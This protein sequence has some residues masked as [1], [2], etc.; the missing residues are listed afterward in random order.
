MKFRIIWFTC[1]FLFVFIPDAVFGDITVSPL[2]ITNIEYTDNIFR[3]EENEESDFITTV[4]FGVDAQYTERTGGVEISYHPSYSIYGQFDENNTLRHDASL[5]AWKYIAEN[6][7]IIF[8]NVFLLTE[9][10][11]SE[12]ELIRDDEIIIGRDDTARTSRNEYYSNSTIAEFIHTWDIENQFRTRFRYRFLENDDPEVEDNEEYRPEIDLVYWFSLFYGIHVNGAYTRGVY[13]EDSE[14]IGIP[15][16][17]FDNWFGSLIFSRRYSRHFF[18][19]LQ[20]DHIY[21]NY[22]GDTDDDYEVYMPSIGFEWQIE[23]DLHLRMGGGGYF[24]QY[25]DEGEDEEGWSLNAIIDKTWNFRRGSMVLRGNTGI[26]QNDFGAQN[27]GLGQFVSVRLDADYDF[28]RKFSGNLSAD[29]RYSD[30][31]SD[32]ED[33]IDDEVI[34]DDEN[35]EDETRYALE[36]GLTYLPYSWM[37]LNLNYRYIHYDINSDNELEDKNISENRILFG[38]ELASDVP[39]RF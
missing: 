10:P 9:D 35:I 11:L 26:D 16:D 20:Y 28:S 31:I 17:D 6:T 2:I 34:S 14:F 15:T 39:C 13:K 24:F 1:F 5:H 36:A 8:D 7:Q 19:F 12:D 3:S 18:L 27:L 22:D 32:E 30:V 23:R 33:R 37:T 38:I 4:S 21:R 25:V 29:F